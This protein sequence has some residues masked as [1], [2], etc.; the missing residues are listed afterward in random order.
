[1]GNGWGDQSFDRMIFLPFPCDGHFSSSL[2]IWLTRLKLYMFFF[3]LVTGAKRRLAH[4]IQIFTIMSPNMRTM[5]ASCNRSFYDVWK[6]GGQKW[7]ILARKMMILINLDIH[8]TS[9]HACHQQ[10]TITHSLLPKGRWYVDRLNLKNGRR[11][12]S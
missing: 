5:F 4:V 3:W 1:M 7:A 6:L 8:V 12:K 2:F 10:P 9:S 11:T